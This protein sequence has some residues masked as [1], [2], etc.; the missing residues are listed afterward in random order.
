MLTYCWKMLQHRF[1]KNS[2][3]D[4]FIDA[5]AKLRDLEIHEPSVLKE[6]QTSGFNAVLDNP[7]LK[8][9]LLSAVVGLQTHFKK[10]QPTRQNVNFVRNV[11]HLVQDW[12][13]E[14][15]DKHKAD[16]RFAKWNEYIYGVSAAFAN[17]AYQRPLTLLVGVMVR[18]EAK[19]LD[20]TEESVRSLGKMRMPDLVRWLSKSSVI[21]THFQR[22]ADIV[23]SPRLSAW[24]LMSKINIKC[25]S[26]PPPETVRVVLSKETLTRFIDDG[27]SPD[28]EP[29]PS[30]VSS[31]LQ[32]LSKALNN[33]DL[34]RS[35]QIGIVLS[36]L[37]M[38][39]QMDACLVDVEFQG[40]VHCKCAVLA[41][42]HNTRAIA[43]PYVG[44]SK[45]SCAFCDYFFK[46]YNK[47]QS[48]NFQ[49]LGGH[50]MNTEWRFPPLLGNDEVSIKAEFCNRLLPVIEN[51]VKT[52]A[53]RGSQSA[54]ASR[55]IRPREVELCTPL[56]LV[57]L[58]PY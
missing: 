22:L 38:R 17:H 45:P 4:L 1:L 12:L 39:T 40:H 50:G 32:S 56:H 42:I 49:T 48:T 30:I 54:H 21:C 46:A 55:E 3:P 5:V 44:A 31:M 28:M 47:S 16:E 58:I 20:T 6:L 53:R 7:K 35:N 26:K 9:D 10:N 25:V 41:H 2:R 8:F 23:V 13:D 51:G 52:L 57:K 14:L 24:L 43:I 33:K 37:S 36:S 11:L 15:S 27:E 29:D 34:P 19:Q 18:A